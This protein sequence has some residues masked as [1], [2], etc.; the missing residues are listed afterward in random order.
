[1]HA[2]HDGRLTS[3]ELLP[4]KNNNLAAPE[5][6]KGGG[7]SLTKNKARKKRRNTYMDQ[8]PRS[9]VF[10]SEEDNR[11]PGDP[12]NDNQYRPIRVQSVLAPY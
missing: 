4:H 3:N 12:N 2:L 9:R 1:M 11:E 7:I 8:E 6:H 5:G 10:G